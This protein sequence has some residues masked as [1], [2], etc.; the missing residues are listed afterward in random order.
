MKREET[1][2]DQILDRKREHV[3]MRKRS[4]SLDAL[5]SA[6]AYNEPRRGFL[7]ALIVGANPVALIAEVKRASPSRGVICDNFDPA[8]IATRYEHG[9]ASCL[10]VL[11]DEP[12]FQ[13]SDQDL[14]AARSA[15]QLPAL[16][17]D[18]II[19]A[20]QLHE[21]KA[22]GADCIL[23]IVAAFESTALLHEL[24]D[25]AQSIG[26]DVLVEVH[27]ERELLIAKAL[28][29]KLLGINNRNLQTFET[30]IATTERLIPLAPQDCFI[31]SES[32]IKDHAHVCRVAGAGAKA[33]LVGESLLIQDDAAGAV[34]SLL[35]R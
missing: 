5:Q 3:E 6:P 34:R 31:V 8:H 29:P 26:L 7:N 32:A 28:N 23:L 2:L 15:T 18:F 22:I 27:D 11:T 17:K 25:E 13:G 16:R 14:I 1:I 10:S 19:D 21:S 20:Y 30:D 9:G 4:A 33:V 24:H 35:G 12:F